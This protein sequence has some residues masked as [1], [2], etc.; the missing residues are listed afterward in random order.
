MVKGPAGAPEVYDVRASA[1]RG[2]RGV[3]VAVSGNTSAGKSTLVERVR[4]ELTERGTQAVGISERLFHHRYLPL[5]FSRS[6]T[7]AFPVQLSFMLERHL[8]LLRNLE[9]GRVVVME[10][11][12]LDDGLFVAEHIETG[13]VQPDQAA[14]YRELSAVLH[15]RV[16]APDVLVLMNP[17]PEVS[18]A[19]LAAA[20]AAG[21]RPRE[22]PDEDAKR[23][24][25][26]RWHELYVD[27]HEEFRK[28]C[29]A[30]PAFAGVRLLE[31][32]PQAPPG[33]A[34]PQVVAAVRDVTRQGRP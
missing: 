9:L 32:D 8:V 23:R 12:H 6:D 3:Y 29:A 14:A 15:R 34:A 24:W 13:S 25:V 27:L 21:E 19:R 31:A 7:Y 17:R 22:F 4:R 2:P 20:E 10:R 26:H 11:S 30:D 16:P 1:A 33:S 18:L 5:M 28:R